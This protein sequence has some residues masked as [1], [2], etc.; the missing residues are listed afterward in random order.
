MK[1]IEPWNWR[2]Y[3]EF[4]LVWPLRLRYR[5]ILFNLKFKRVSYFKLAVTKYEDTIQWSKGYPDGQEYIYYRR[6]IDR[7]INVLLILRIKYT[8]SSDLWIFHDRKTVLKSGL[9]K[10]GMYCI[11]FY[12]PNKKFYLSFVWRVEK[13]LLVSERHTY[14]ANNQSFVSFSFFMQ[15]TLIFS[16]N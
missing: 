12:H 14:F 1:P 13:R 5:K 2:E 15:L 7:Y 16:Y 4:R 3:N 8:A 10:S 11:E 9:Q 6:V